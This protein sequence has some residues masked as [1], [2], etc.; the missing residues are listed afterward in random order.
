MFIK[1]YFNDK[2]LFLCDEMNDEINSYAHHDDAVLIDEFSPPAVNSII[3]EMWQQKI[4]AGIFLH[5]DLEQLKKAVWKKFDIIKAGGGLVWN[6]NKE[7]LF[8]FRRGK[9]DLPKGK[10]EM[11]ETLEQCAVRE[12]EE[13][14]GLK[15]IVLKKELL[16]TYHTYE[17]S[18][19]HILKESY[20]FE[21]KV[22][23]VQNLVPQAIEDIHEIKWVKKENLP[24]VLGNTF[25]SIKD[26]VA[27]VLKENG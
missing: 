5:H 9:W 4:H 11:G 17:E 3:H 26:V 7:M 22:S 8:I 20:W 18:G 1:I 13:E 15:N 23:G 21:M 14:T 10:L 2:P 19:K 12:V 25:P 6:E 24:Q 16:S 27:K